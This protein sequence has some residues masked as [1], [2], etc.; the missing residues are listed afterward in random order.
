MPQF[1]HGG[2]RGQRFCANSTCAG[3]DDR[4]NCKNS[5]DFNPPRNQKKKGAEDSENTVE[6]IRCSIIQT[7]FDEGGEEND[8][9]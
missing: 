8:R 7:C 1:S 3:E 2:Q 5:G 6:E 9:G 4:R